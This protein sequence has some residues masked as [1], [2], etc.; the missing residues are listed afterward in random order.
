MYAT[1]DRRTVN[2]ARLQETG[3]RAE[4]D[5]FPALRRADGFVDFHVI[6]DANGENEAV[7]YWE[8]RAQAEAFQPE[9]DPWL[10]TLEDLG[11]GLRSTG[12]GD[13]VFQVSPAERGRP[14]TATVGGGV[15]R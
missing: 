2:Q 11:H 6:A 14:A 3:E 8:T 13:I 12:G 5:F 15:A 9:L 10:R 7:T 1:I 4:R